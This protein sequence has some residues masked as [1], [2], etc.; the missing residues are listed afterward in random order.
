MAG[1]RLQRDQARAGT[2]LARAREPRGGA[3][4]AVRAS[5]GGRTT[6]GA[7]VTVIFSS[8]RE[9]ADRVLAKMARESGGA[10]VSNDREVR[11]LAGRAGAVVVTTDQFLERIE[12][13][14]HPQ[15]IHEPDMKSE[16]DEHD[17]PARGS[18]KA[19]NP[20]RL[21]KKE[22]AAKRALGRLDRGRF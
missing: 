3:P 17:E 9:S 11:S 6:G 1:R 7:G 13:G 5:R 15:R 20:R 4:R 22:R 18:R 14:R 12:R 8:A 19:G 21:S 10:V 16:K 2:G